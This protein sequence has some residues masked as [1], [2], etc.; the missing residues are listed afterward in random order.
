MASVVTFFLCVQLLSDAPAVLRERRPLQAAA[1]AAAAGP[2]Q[3]LCLK[4]Q[5]R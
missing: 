3:L 1:A 2:P 5:L 4:R